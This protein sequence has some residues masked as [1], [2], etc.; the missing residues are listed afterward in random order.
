M[1]ALTQP[2]HLPEFHHRPEAGPAAR[3]PPPPPPHPGPPL[4]PSP[5][6][7]YHCTV[8]KV[9]RLLPSTAISYAKSSQRSVLV[10]NSLN[11]AQNNRQPYETIEGIRG[12]STK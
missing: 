3:P 5:P 11:N 7:A 1:A 6:S 4:A 12:A 2:A 10:T 8:A 9:Q